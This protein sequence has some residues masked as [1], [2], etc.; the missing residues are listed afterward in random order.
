MAF[1]RQDWGEF[2]FPWVIVV[3][4]ISAFCLVMFSSLSDN[5]SADT[6]APW[7]PFAE[8]AFL[9]QKLRSVGRQLSS[10]GPPVGRVVQ[11]V[12]SNAAA[13]QSDDDTGRSLG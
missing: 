10:A 3:A 1:V 9:E 7:R 8:L 4:L 2:T 12:S 6:P 5:T 13:P 11:A